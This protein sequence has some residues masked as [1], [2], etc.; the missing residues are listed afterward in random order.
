MA[1]TSAARKW[2]KRVERLERSGLSQRAF[3]AREGLAAGSLSFWKW[4]LR[5]EGAGKGEP[6]PVAP[7]NFIELTAKPESQPSRAAM[8]FEVQLRSGR[9]VRVVAGFDAAEL[10]RLV[11]IL[12]EVR[13]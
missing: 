11:E 8:A 9:S 2:A 4:K 13:S 7:V 5:Q 3:A 10:A 12:E 6:A 1:G